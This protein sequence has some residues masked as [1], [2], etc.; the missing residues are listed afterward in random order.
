MLIFLL[1]SIVHGLER[2]NSQSFY[3]FYTEKVYPDVLRVGQKPAN[4]F[5]LPSSENL[6][7]VKRFTYFKLL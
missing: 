6:L 4:Y 3:E 2:Y 5:Q 7:K 1:F